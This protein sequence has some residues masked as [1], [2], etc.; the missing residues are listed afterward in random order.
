MGQ[1]TQDYKTEK[2]RAKTDKR[3]EHIK[4]EEKRKGV[5]DERDCFITDERSSG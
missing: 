3:A 4:K 5:N 2:S 1:R